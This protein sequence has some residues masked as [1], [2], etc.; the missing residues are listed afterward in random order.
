[1]Q[2]QLAALQRRVAQLEV[3]L[4]GRPLTGPVM[5]TGRLREAYVAVRREC[6]ELA[7]LL[8][9]IKAYE[10]EITAKAKAWVKQ[11]DRVPRKRR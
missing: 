11:V 5:P 4:A 2:A 9:Q 7:V 1:M 8:A 10:P 6:D 3:E